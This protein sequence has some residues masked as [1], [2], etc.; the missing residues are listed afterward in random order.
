[1][2]KRE[3]DQELAHQMQKVDTHLKKN[4]LVTSHSYEQNFIRNH[5][6][7][8]KEQAPGRKDWSSI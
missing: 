2:R 1:M 7:K 3:V 8:K 4:E 6:C 5:V